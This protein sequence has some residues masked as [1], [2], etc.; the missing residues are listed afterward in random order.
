MSARADD[1]Q[2]RDTE[3]GPPDLPPVERLDFFQAVFM[4]ERLL[5]A[6]G[7]RPA[8][9]G[10]DTRP[11]NEPVRFRTDPSLRFAAR[12][13]SRIELDSGGTGGD[14]AHVWITFM[15]LAGRSSP[16]PAQYAKE[17]IRQNRSRNTA[18]HEFLD[19]LS[20]R[21]VSF[22]YRAWLKHSPLHSV[23]DD[24]VG[25]GRESPLLQ[26][27]FAFA[28]YADARVRRQS[29][30]PDWIFLKYVGLW[31][32][33]S[34]PPAG[35]QVILADYLGVPVEIGE[36]R[37]GRVA[38]DPREQTRLGALGGNPD[39]A[40][41][42]RRAMLGGSAYRPDAAFRIRLGPMSLKKFT[43]LLPGGETIGHAFALARCYTREETDFDV[44]LVLRGEEAPGCRLG[45]DS[46]EGTRLG[47]TSWLVLAPAPG[48]LDDAIFASGE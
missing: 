30:L 6:G 2:A 1:G 11:A 46:G 9:V 15:G 3:R 29:G 39:D 5:D 19:L 25:R 24:L 35:L 23:H 26:A 17:V 10:R 47:W 22:F 34:R 8:R 13:V 18:L 33:Q 44:Q 42:G 4:L 16:L 12:T 20:H 31:A 28:G 21:L 48:N 27:L 32:M 38:L 45:S 41:L 7:D 14:R 36:F 43:G 40:R 37:G